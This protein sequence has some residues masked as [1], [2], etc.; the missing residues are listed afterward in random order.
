M[1]SKPTGGQGN[2]TSDYGRAALLE[3]AADWDLFD[4][5]VRL[6][7]SGVN[8][9][10]ALEKAELLEEMDRF[11]IRSALVS[12]WAGEEYDAA[13]G[14]EALAREADARLTAAW[15]A[16]PGLG[17]LEELAKRRPLA[18]RMTPGVTQH[19]FSLA[20]WSA[21]P[22]L[23]YLQDH[24]ILTLIARADIAWTEV[25]TTLEN[26]PRLRL[27]L[28]DAG[29]RVD[30]YLFPLLDRFPSLYFDSATYL[31][32]R[33]LES[34]VEGRGSER[35]LFGSR[36]PLFTPASSLGVLASARIAD[37]DKRAIAGGNLR[38]LLAEAKERAAIQTGVR[39]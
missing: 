16:L 36:L 29:Y 12:H 20:E 15:A 39:S 31:A 19:S 6:G 9:E 27:V 3:E 5:N 14:N 28:L 7:P 22:M 23:E 13:I 26:F 30:R 18:V 25:V 37:A 2:I 8:G 10:L 4:V 21:G 35:V 17:F 38:R 33:Q 32:H 24:A 1:R 11:F 34:F